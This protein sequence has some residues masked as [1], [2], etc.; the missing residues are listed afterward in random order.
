MDRRQR[1][2][3]GPGR[4]RVLSIDNSR[5]RIRLRRSAVIVDSD[6]CPC[7]GQDRAAVLWACH[8]GQRPTSI[9]PISASRLWGC[10]RPGAVVG[11]TFDCGDGP[12]RSGSP[13]LNGL[14]A[15]RQEVR[16][17]TFSR[18]ARTSAM[19]LRPVSEPARHVVQG[20]AEV[21]QLVGDGDRHSWRHGAGE[22]AIV[23]E[24]P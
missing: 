13:V 16:A 5:S 7:P 12:A 24:R 9:P 10:R 14:D 22:Q 15:G 11:A 6:R 20:E 21:G 4:R 8:S 1:V 19:C 2:G 18:C 17:S 3:R 23:L